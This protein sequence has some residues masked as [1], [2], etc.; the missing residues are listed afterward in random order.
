MTYNFRS[1]VN[2]VLR[3]TE[4]GPVN[5]SIEA[6]FSGDNIDPIIDRIKDWTNEVYIE[7]CNS[8]Y[9]RF[10][11]TE[12]SFSSVP[13]QETYSLANDCITNRIINVREMK[14]PSL[15]TRIDFKNL[16]KL[17]PD[18]SITASGTP[19]YYYF[20]NN[21][22]SLFPVPDSVMTIKYRY[23]KTV[24]ELSDSTDLPLI[25]EHWKW[26]WVN[27]VL[28]RANQYLQDQSLADVQV[29]Y[30]NGLLQM[31]AHNRADRQHK[32]S[33]KPY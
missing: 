8:G 19:S 18:T 6:Q 5:E 15:L 25:P 9:W 7:I 26:V 4:F 13:A 1:V 23:Y 31:R 24:T 14:T 29:Q 10:L 32:N 17:Y 11:E 22:I 33:I 12:A 21:N 2:H 16:D 30:F 28:L 3:K 20:E 27:G